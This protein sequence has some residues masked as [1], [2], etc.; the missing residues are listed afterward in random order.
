MAD[1]GWRIC[2]AGYPAPA[3]GGSVEHGPYE[4]EARGFGGQE[5]DDF[6]SVAGFAEGV[7]GELECLIRLWC[8]RG[9]AG[10]WSAARG[11]WAGISPR[12]GRRGCTAG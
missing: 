12:P 8:S 3:A 5:V 10:S 6:D 9:S 1:L 2:G 4:V 7:F 11:R